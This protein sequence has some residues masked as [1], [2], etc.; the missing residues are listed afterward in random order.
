MASSALDPRRD[1]AQIARNLAR[2]ALPWDTTR[3]LELAL[4]RTFASPRIGGLLHATGEFEARSQKRYEDTD[5]I[6]SEIVEHG[7]DSDRIA[8]S[9]AA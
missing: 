3:S 4:F 1:C 2:V 7:Y 8:R 5:L 6:V 9:A